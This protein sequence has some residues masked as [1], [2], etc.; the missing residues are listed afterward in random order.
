[1]IGRS[2]AVAKRIAELTVAFAAD[3]N[4]ESSALQFPKLTASIGD[5]SIEPGFLNRCERELK[6]R[7][8]AHG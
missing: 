6:L 8:W 3:E 2:V 5:A 7:Q 1:M 4:P